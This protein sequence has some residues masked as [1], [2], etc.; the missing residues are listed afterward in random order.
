[1]RIKTMQIDTVYQSLNWKLR[2][3]GYGW[4]F[5]LHHLPSGESLWFQDKNAS[6]FEET[7]QALEYSGKDGDAIMSSLWFVYSGA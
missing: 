7:M 5:E 3:V 6:D 4:G 2:S 1:M